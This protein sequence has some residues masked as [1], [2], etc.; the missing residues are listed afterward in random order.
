MNIPVVA[1]R[2]GGVPEIVDDGKGG[3]LVSPQ[4]PEEIADGLCLL[5]SDADMRKRMGAH[6]TERVKAVFGVREMAD[7]Y[8]MVY[9]ATAGR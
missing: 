6:N 9:R 7:K 5:L 2:V 3:I 1:T 8:Q 4:K